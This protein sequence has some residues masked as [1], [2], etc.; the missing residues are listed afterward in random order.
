[1]E[2]YKPLIVNLPSRLSLDAKGDPTCVDR[3]FI[4]LISLISV[5]AEDGE[6]T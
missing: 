6:K 5:V 2:K 3:P 4:S 1:M